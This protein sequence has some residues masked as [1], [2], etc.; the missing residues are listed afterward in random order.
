MGLFDGIKNNRLLKQGYNNEQIKAITYVSNKDIFNYVDASYA[1][2]DIYDI[3]EFLNGPYKDT[4][5]GMANINKEK[6]LL[7]IRALNEQPGISKEIIN[8]VLSMANNYD[9]KV[10]KVVLANMI[11]DNPDTAFMN[12]IKTAIDQNVNIN[13]LNYFEFEEKEKRNLS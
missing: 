13:N 8:F 12:L 2:Q 6:R 10:L 7:I 1:V 9:D 4:M 11:C 3:G 5:Y